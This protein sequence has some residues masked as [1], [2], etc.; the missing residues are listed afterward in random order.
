VLEV[1]FDEDDVGLGRHPLDVIARESAEFDVGLEHE[2]ATGVG[3]DAGGDGDLSILI[4][5]GQL[6]IQVGQLVPSRRQF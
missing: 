6:L 2:V 5:L 4:G 1:A 3:G